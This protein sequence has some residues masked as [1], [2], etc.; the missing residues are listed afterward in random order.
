M[1]IYL[2]ILGV[3]LAA[4]AGALAAVALRAGSRGKR[5]VVDD[6]QIG[7]QFI[8]DAINAMDKNDC[9]KR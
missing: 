3:A 7:E 4:G 8:F 5:S 6:E 1:F 2:I 9:G